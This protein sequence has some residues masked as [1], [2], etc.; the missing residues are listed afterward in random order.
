MSRPRRLLECLGA[1]PRVTL[2]L[3]LSFLALQMLSVIPYALLSALFVAT[4]FTKNE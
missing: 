2:K 4:C 3:I 1:Q